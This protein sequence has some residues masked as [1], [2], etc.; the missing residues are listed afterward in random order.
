M[1]PDRRRP[2][3]R[4]HSIVSSLQCVWRNYTNPLSWNFLRWRH[5][6]PEV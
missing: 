6:A 5:K 1:W 2:R 3:Q 4:R